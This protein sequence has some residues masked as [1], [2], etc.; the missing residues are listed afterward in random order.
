MAALSMGDLA[1]TFML[2][3]QNVA[4]KHSLQQLSTEVTTGVVSDITAR[5]SGDLGQISGIDSA[6]AR[7]RGYGAVTLE[8]GLFA[9]AM[10][11]ALGTIDSMASDLSTHLLSASNGTADARVDAAGADGEQKLQAALAAMNT[12]VGDRSLFAGVATQ[13]AAVIDA[14]SLL[15]ALGGAVSG[16]VSAA[17]V[18]TA[19]TAWFASPTGYDAIAYQGA[20]ALT[21]MLISPGEEAQIDVTAQ[22]P[23]LRDTLKGLA[24]AA[25]LNRGVLAGQP[26]ARQDLAQRA[27]LRLFENQTDRTNVAA[28]LG[29]T[30]AKIEAAATRN[31][32]EVMSLQIAR[33]GIVQADPYE[34]ATKLEQA[35][36]Q[37]EKIYAI[38]AR[39]SRLSLM[40]YLK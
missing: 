21:N 11:T 12:R 32:N 7:L 14:D 6:L 26:Q 16:A 36:A 38:T 5:V 10:Q 27:G 35:Q 33:N 24:M 15:T 30:E 28:R 22:D 23:R 20:A 31:S 25:L 39:M 3:R 8:A 1:Q 13:G 34:A 2:R 4:M 18:E 40:D 37:L 19:V 29:L 9:G 17:D